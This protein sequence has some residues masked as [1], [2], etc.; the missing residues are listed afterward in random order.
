M[1]AVSAS[2]GTSSM[3]TRTFYF[4]GNLANLKFS[5][6]FGYVSTMVQDCMVYGDYNPDPPYDRACIEYG[7][8]YLT[9][10]TAGFFI[11]DV[12]IVV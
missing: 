6:D 10:S 12:A 8:P 1:A 9:A 11:Y 2:D 4:D 3:Q 5:V 7:D